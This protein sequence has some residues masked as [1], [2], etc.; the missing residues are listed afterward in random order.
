[1]LGDNLACFVTLKYQ[2]P[3]LGQVDWKIYKVLTQQEIKHIDF[4][5]KGTTYQYVFKLKLLAHLFSKTL[6]MSREGKG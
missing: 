5:N 6:S 1:M 2:G 3:I 4:E